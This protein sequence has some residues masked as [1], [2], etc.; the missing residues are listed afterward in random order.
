M[1]FIFDE[2]Y[3]HRLAEGLN[4]F[5]NGDRKNKA[6]EI[7]HI[8][9][10]AEHLKIKPKNG[11]SF[12]DEEV[13][14]IAG[15]KKGII[16]TQDN[17]FKKIKHYHALYKEHNVGIVFFKTVINSKGYWNMVASI[18]NKWYDLKSATENKHPPFCYS[19][20]KKNFEERKF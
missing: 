13:I 15:K 10:L 6:A 3:S 4:H 1:V 7:W 18:I 19:L 14:E 2:N 16:I 5:E 9:G 11:K 20:D 8:K 12:T 17:D